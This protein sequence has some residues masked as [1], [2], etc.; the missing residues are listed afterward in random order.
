M[1]KRTLEY[2][3]RPNLNKGQLIFISTSRSFNNA[4]KAL[5]FYARKELDETQNNDGYPFQ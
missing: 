2:T 5:I 4:V 3:I 1:I